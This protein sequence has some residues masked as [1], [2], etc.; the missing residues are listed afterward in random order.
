MPEIRETVKTFMRKNQMDHES[1]DIRRE[2]EVFLEDMQR[3]LDGDRECLDMLPTYIPMTENIPSHERVIVM[4]AGGTNF[5]VAVVHFD[6]ENKPVIEDFANY[7]MPGAGKEVDKEEFFR[8]VAEY[9][10]P[11]IHKS[12]KI[13]FCF[14]YPT[15]VLPNGDGKLLRFSKEI[16]VRDMVGQPVGAGILKALR[17]AGYTEP[18]RIVLLNDTVA[19]LLGGKAAYANMPYDSFIGYI[20]GTGTN[21]CYIERGSRIGKLHEEGRNYD[22]MLINT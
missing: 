21:T 11:V 5:R 4:D 15:D 18:K 8:T 17:N 10:K 9:L 22:T 1:I 19:T 6:G 16:R 12:N 14:S 13:G 3:G 2:C 7:P 20:L